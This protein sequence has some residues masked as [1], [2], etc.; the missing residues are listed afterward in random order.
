[1]A[2]FGWKIHGKL[3]RGSIIPRNWVL[4]NQGFL[5]FLIGLDFF[6]W[7]QNLLIGGVGTWYSGIIRVGK[8]GPKVF[9]GWLIFWK[10][11]ERVNSLVGSLGPKQK[12]QLNGRIYRLGSFNKY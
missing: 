8:I 3:N 10:F 2:I 5:N 6:Y 1:L 11:Q 7:D 12:F 9:G 4:I